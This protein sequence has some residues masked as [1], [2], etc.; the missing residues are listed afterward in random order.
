MLTLYYA[1][2][3]CSMASHIALE[4]SGE[5]YEPRKVDLAG[6]EQRT[7][8]YLKMNPL[9]RVPVLGLDDGTP[10]TENTAILPYLGKRFDLWPKDALGDAKALSLIGYF[11]SSVH[12][13]HAHVGRPERYT[14]DTS[15]FPGIKDA[16]LK[17]FQT[18]LKQIDGMLAG[19][20]WFG[21]KYSVLD[22]Y[23][24]VFYTWG[25]RRDLP[26]SELK[27]YTAHKDRMLKRAAVGRVVENEK[28]KV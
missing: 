1:P 19:R 2:G 13:A 3:A 21:D 26:M 12:P 15:A 18:Y 14:A 22:P 23:G 8:A 28:V 4:E 27:N 5:K 25:V 24:F 17:T 6:G 7:E 9:G 10:L 20:E 16:G 11:A